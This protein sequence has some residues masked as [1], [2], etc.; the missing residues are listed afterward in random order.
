MTYTALDLFCGAGGAS[1]G[2]ERAGF[3]L[4]AAIDSNECALQT[5][6][7]NLKSPV[8][9]HDLS[10]VDSSI[11]PTQDVNYIHGSP[12]CQGFS[13]ANDERD[14][15]DP[16]NALVFD[17]VDWVQELQPAVVS[18]EN[19]TGMLSITTGFMDKLKAAYRNA[20]YGVKYRTLNAANYGVPQIRNRVYTIAIREDIKTPSRWFP[21][22]THSKG[23]SQTLSGN[24]LSEWLNI[25]EAFSNLPDLGTGDNHSTPE[26]TKA[27]KE[28]IESTEPGESL[29]DSYQERVR[30][31]KRSP[32]PTLKAGKRANYHFAHPTEPRKLTIRERARIMGFPDWFTFTGGITEQRKQ[33]GNAVPPPLQEAV[34]SQLKRLYISGG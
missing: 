10:D 16:R 34:A 20:G 30:L 26:M 14:E 32:A 5:H 13:N 22:P 3:E 12:P 18:M 28:R 8:V 11:L 25:K 24:T 1:L 2:I 6:K 15:S 27:T 23:G 19:V 4:V 33:T 7:H 9:N 29:F 31:D 21:Q 17:F